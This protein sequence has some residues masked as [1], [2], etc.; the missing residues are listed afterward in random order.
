MTMLEKIAE[1]T[2]ERPSDQEAN[3]KE[4]QQQQ[5]AS[6]SLRH[7]IK[8]S[9]F[10]GVGCKD[11]LW[12]PLERLQKPSVKTLTPKTAEEPVGR[13]VQAKSAGEG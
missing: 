3:D 5:V 8:S 10:E 12:K 6:N 13:A 1:R 2:S 9:G 11:P 4:P 7:A